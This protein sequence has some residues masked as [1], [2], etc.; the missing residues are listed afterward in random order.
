M[1]R[2]TLSKR[3]LGFIQDYI[4]ALRTFIPDRFSD[5]FT[6]PCWYADIDVPPES[7]RQ[8]KISTT[9][10]ELESTSVDEVSK[11]LLK[12][13]STGKERLHGNQRD[14]TLLCLPA[15]YLAGFPK[16]GTSTLYKLITAHP[17]IATPPIKEG[18]FWYFMMNN[19][20]YVYNA[21]KSYYYLFH[22]AEAAKRIKKNPQT[23]TLDASP[24]TIF[25]TSDHDVPLLVDTDICLFPRIASTVLPDTKYIV[26]LR[27]PITRLWSDYWFYC[28]I[29]NWKTENG[30][31]KVPKGYLNHGAD[32]F[33]RHSVAG[34]NEY[35]SCLRQILSL[36]VLG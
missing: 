13:I 17:K 30:E 2:G 31:V 3:Q 32:M 4:D 29:N 34:I 10:I 25:V 5:S 9:L 33:H 14:G 35:K 27:N 19:D 24:S 22:F 1:C 36:S 6:N 15:F 23:L 26:I 8:Q 21:L 12:I 16:C 28:A 20:Q 7:I 18:H 11:R